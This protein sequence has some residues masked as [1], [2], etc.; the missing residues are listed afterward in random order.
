MLNPLA[1]DLDLSQEKAALVKKQALLVE[2]EKTYAAYQKALAAYNGVKPGKTAKADSP[3]AAPAN[4]V[5]A[6][7]LTPA[8][9][10]EIK[11]AYASR[12]EGVTAKDM[13]F[14]ITAKAKPAKKLKGVTKLM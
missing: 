2:V 5:R 3:A 10:A 8:R 4:R 12:K 9:K 13:V 7:N 1:M 6:P 11:K 14:K